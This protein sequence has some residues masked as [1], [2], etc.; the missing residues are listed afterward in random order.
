MIDFSLSSSWNAR[1][2][3]DARSMI[4]EIKAL[5]FKKVELNFTLTSGDIRDIISL[6]KTEGLEITGLHNFCP[7]PEGV[8]PDKASPD[9]Y[10]L[11]SLEEA[12]RTKKLYNSNSDSDND[13]DDSNNDSDS[14]SDYSYPDTHDEDK[15]E[16]ENNELKKKILNYVDN[17]CKYDDMD[18]MDDT[19]VKICDIKPFWKVFD[20]N[21]IVHNIDEFILHDKCK[22]YWTPE[23]K[24]YALRLWNIVNPSSDTGITFR[25]NIEYYKVEMLDLIKQGDLVKTNL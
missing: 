19:T 17:G 7:I 12:E 20:I 23:Q 11:S 10:L 1:V 16:D 2:S 8:T 21:Y 13:I 6:K 22:L 4:H 9:Y 15:D 24:S 18:N 14:D 5:G 3:K 25:Q